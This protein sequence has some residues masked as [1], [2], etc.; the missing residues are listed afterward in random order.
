MSRS[1]PNPQ[2]IGLL[3]PDPSFSIM[4]PRIPIR[5]KYLRIWNTS[6]NQPHSDDQQFLD[7]K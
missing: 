4:D 6:G 3:D 5:K 1:N 2:L 7:P